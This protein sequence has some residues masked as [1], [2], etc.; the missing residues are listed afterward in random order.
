MRE[1]FSGFLSKES[2]RVPLFESPKTEEKLVP[3]STIAGIIPY[4][5]KSAILVEKGLKV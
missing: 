3:C 1:R 5:D 4:F 2:A